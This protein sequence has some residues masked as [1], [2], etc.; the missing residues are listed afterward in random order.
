MKKT[1]KPTKLSLDRKTIKQL[2]SQELPQANAG[3]ESGTASLRFFTHC[4]G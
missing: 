4:P 1:D 2:S 3:A